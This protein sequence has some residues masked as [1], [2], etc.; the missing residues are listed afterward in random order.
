MNSKHVFAMSIVAVGLT[1]SGGSA[2]ASDS[3]KGMVPSGD[4]NSGSANSGVFSGVPDPN[5]PGGTKE[6]G[7]SREGNMEIEKVRPGGEPDRDAVNHL[8]LAWGS[9][10]RPLAPPTLQAAGGPPGVAAT[11]VALAM[12]LMR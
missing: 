5:S 3:A 9:P 10:R 7:K 1:W 4:M 12:H 8:D 2:M 6:A 11:E